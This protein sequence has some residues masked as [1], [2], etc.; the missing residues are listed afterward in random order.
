[1][2]EGTDLPFQAKAKGSSPR[3]T[4]PS[5]GRSR[6]AAAPEASG[7]A[8]TAST[9]RFKGAEI[10]DNPVAKKLEEGRV[11]MG[12][13]LRSWIS[14]NGWTY[15]DVTS[16][17][18]SLSGGFSL[19]HGSQISNLIRGKL[20]PKP[21][22]FMGLDYLNKACALSQTQREKLPNHLAEK[23]IGVRVVRSHLFASAEP[24]NAGDFLNLFCGVKPYPAAWLD[25]HN[26]CERSIYTYLDKLAT[27]T[28]K[29]IEAKKAE[30]MPSR[31][32]IVK[33]VPARA[34]AYATGALSA[35]YTLSSEQFEELLPCYAQGFSKWLGAVVTPYK[36]LRSINQS[37]PLQAS[38]EELLS[39]FVNSETTLNGSKKP[40]TEIIDIPVSD[41]ENWASHNA[42]IEALDAHEREQ[43]DIPVSDEENWASHNEL[44]ELLKADQAGADYLGV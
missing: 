14:L 19:L 23:L 8:K 30:N 20:E 32:T 43:F 27:L 22:L 25:S 38:P 12:S 33:Y 7:G 3:R 2:A 35:N 15:D 10:Q 34:K 21:R 31:M 13:L 1:M 44:T 26:L 28:H 4:P 37:P 5:G 17:V 6:Q 42:Y 36:L 9:D 11:A 16:I 18:E 29:L 41:E 40:W 39:H 24:W